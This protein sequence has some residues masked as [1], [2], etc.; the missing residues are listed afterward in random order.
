[1]SKLLEIDGLS[2]ALTIPTG[3]LH[4]VRDVS[5]TL[6]RGEALGI[7]GESG[8]G[9]SM[10]AL[11]LMR[12]L[13]GRAEATGSL[14]FDGADLG[15]V[16]DEAFSRQYL[17]HRIAM[18]FQ[19]P[20]TSLNP[21]Y[22]IGRQ[23]SE[24]AVIFGGKS[25]R[26]AEARALFL[27][28]R[29][30]IPDPVA[31]LSQY[32]HQLSG[33]QR[34]RVMIALALMLEPE[35]LI[36]DEPTTALDVTVQAQILDLLRD[37]RREM[38]MAMILI[39]H[40][41]AVVAEQT[42]RV[43]V[44]YGGEMIE[45][46]RAEAVMADPAHPYTRAL[47]GAIPR[48]D[49]APR[50]LGAIP[51]TVPSLTSRPKGCVFAPRCDFARP[52]CVEGRPPVR[53]GA[54]HSRRCVLSDAE[55]PAA[56][57]A[58]PLRADH[59]AAAQVEAVIEARDIT[60]VFTSRKGMFG[61]R[62]TIH[63]VDGV[64]LS[65]MRGETLALVGESGS[66]KSTLARIMLGLNLPTSGT[67][68][69]LGKPVADL[70]PLE[71]AA[72]V[73]PVFQD[74]YSSLNPRR[75]LAE[76]I[77]RPLVLRGEDD[78]DACAQKAREAMEMVRLPARLLHS[79]PSQ[80]SGGQRQRVAIARALVTRPQALVCDEPTSALDVSVQAQVL[81]LL[82]DLQ[83]ELGLSCLVITHDMAVVHQ[84]ADRVAVMLNG[85]LVEEGSCA[86]VLGSPSSD[87]T[88]RLLAAAPQFRPEWQAAPAAEGH[89]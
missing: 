16:S 87:Y 70:A 43:A 83:A 14:R 81:N 77:A 47:L 67:V 1:M 18:I 31:R 32:P 86:Q 69:M 88:A 53:G 15:A 44:M 38:G 17:G 3:R 9:K 6:E 34:Q 11:A 28:E 19:E 26:E 12:L 52:E 7:V 51:G 22:T 63:A 54:D 85:Q 57:A 82:G 33:G 21:V 73:Q 56:M 27:L 72:L 35:L 68:T 65:L 24:A 46:G 37:L 75:T 49:G 76:I 64:S 20:M 84:V 4:A 62:H 36:A 41:L 55:R 79:Y 66:G 71:R 58:A 42:D 2:V 78:A 45:E 89:V 74:P 5:I 61:A 13:P 8:S 40:D 30:G 60:Q 48:M 23:L 59:V 10:S 25:Q 29:V 39:T 50:R 80:L